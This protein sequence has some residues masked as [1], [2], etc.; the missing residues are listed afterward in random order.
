MWTILKK[1]K[2]ELNLEFTRVS[3]IIFSKSG[4]QR[5]T[6]QTRALPVGLVWFINNRTTVDTRYRRIKRMDTTGGTRREGIRASPPSHPRHYS[7]PILWPRQKQFEYFSIRRVFPTEQTREISATWRKIYSPAFAQ[8]RDR[9]LDLM[10]MYAAARR[11]E[12]LEI[13]SFFEKR[14]GRGGEGGGKNSLLQLTAALRSR[15]WKI[16][17]VS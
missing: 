9:R 6:C 7:S 12:Q 16:R 2:K 8:D 11:D 15:N 3:P 5:N 17:G 4:E 10:Q 1:K 13:K 14:R